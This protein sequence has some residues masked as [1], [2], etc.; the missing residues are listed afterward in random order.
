MPFAEINLTPGVNTETSPA[1]NPAGV[2][3]SNFIRWRANLPEKRGGCVLYVDQAVNGIPCALKP[4]GTFENEKYLAIATPEQVYAYRD[5]PPNS[6]L[7]DISPQYVDSP[8]SDPDF[9][10]IE[11]SSEVTI[12]DTTAPNLEYG[13][14]VEFITPVS[15]GGL[16]LNSTYPVTSPTAGGSYK[17]DAGYPATSTQTVQKATLPNFTTTAGRAR[18][19][20]EFPI[21]YQFNSLAVGNRFGLQIPVVVGGITLFGQY[22]VTR[23]LDTSPT[24]FTFDADDVATSSATN[25]ELNSGFLYLTYWKVSPPGT[26]PSPT[27]S[28]IVP[29]AE[30]FKAPGWWLDTVQSTLIACAINGPIFSYSPISGYTGL[31]IIDNS[32]PHS[33]GAFVAM[34]SG[35]IMAWGT[36]DA[37]DPVQNPLYIRWSDAANINNWTI[38]GQSQAGFYTIPTGSKIVR[39]IQAQNQQL[40]FT[41][42][43][44]YSAQY[45]AYPDFFSFLKIGAGCGL[46]APRAVAIVNN[47]TYWMS[48]EQFFVCQGGSAPT[49]LPCTVWDFIFQNSDQTNLANTVCGGNSLFNEVNWFFPTK[50]ATNG[51]PDAYVCYNT[52]Y[53]L[54]DYGYLSR[55]AWTDQSVLGFPI[56]ADSNG[57]IY[58]H[59]IG[60]NLANGDGDPLPINAS[61]KT[62]YASIADGAN[63]VFVD[64]V[65]PDMKWGTYENPV[66]A[67]V[68]FT[69]YVTDYAGQEPRVYGPYSAKKTN[70]PDETTLFLSPRFRGRFM[71]IKISSSDFG[72][73]WRL[74]SVR[75]RF[76]PSGSR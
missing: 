22:V 9:S 30:V 26:T 70:N 17:I 72:S 28:P 39:G 56:G 32:P 68:D 3:E 59:E 18:V 2:Q 44:V 74:G 66:G 7:K 10:T 45:T 61:I 46:I 73:F 63:L 33:A 71:A 64:W 21:Q 14:S 52:L 42:I 55:T 53:N 38:G 5:D 51:I 40:W 75:Y 65:L 6:Y 34:P 35:Q 13:D 37:L 4:W 16:I 15:I 24:T 43:D 25:V 67:T 54:W 48:Q 11:G 12:A 31:S 69:F 47:S 20:V 1:D 41:D 76:A 58:Q 27:P 57:W 23:I 50:E 8:L 29:G 49:P 62:G 19:I 36:S 60:Y